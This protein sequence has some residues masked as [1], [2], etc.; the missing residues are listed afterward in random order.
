[1][2]RAATDSSLRSAGHAVA[3]ALAIALTLVPVSAVHAAQDASGDDS[4]PPV[5]RQSAEAPS[6]E[7]LRAAG[8]EPAPV[9]SEPLGVRLH[10][11][12]KSRVEHNE[13]RGK[14]SLLLADGAN[15]PPTW[16]LRVLR[17]VTVETN[18][19][20]GQRMADQIEKL[21]S[22]GGDAFTVSILSN[23]PMR[24][25]DREAQLA[26]IKQSFKEGQS[27]VSGTLLVPA[28]GRTM[29]AFSVY[30]TPNDLDQVRSLMNK[31]F[32]T[33]TLRDTSQV[34]AELSARLKNGRDLLA[35]LTPQRL[36][37]LAGETM[38]TRIYRP[39]GS[40][41][42][43]RG[44]QAGEQ[45]V[46]YSQVQIIK[47]PRGAVDFNKR[48]SNYNAAE[49]EQGLLVRIRG[50]VIGS[51]RRG[52]FYDSVAAYWVAWDQSEELWSVVGTHR[53]G[54]A[55]RSE[56]ETGVRMAPSVSRPEPILQVHRAEA[57]GPYEWM[58]P[59]V[60]LSQS[61]AWMLGKVLPRDIDEPREYAWYHYNGRE[62]EPKLT[63]RVDRWEK[64]DDGSGHWI[65][66][67]RLKPDAE[68]IIT[69]YDDEGNFIRQTRPDGV[70]MEPTT[71]KELRRLW[72][73]KGLP[74]N[75]GS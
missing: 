6:P 19:S 40:G 13:V 73:S 38:W 17:V 37:S 15:T 55:S 72:E 41:D 11:P 27:A 75:T 14:P 52:I 54:Q 24:I 68:A 36:Q 16:T 8:L 12:L 9:T 51:R 30:T 63:R 57:S 22:A 2:S 39:D 62:A 23:E 67:T 42:P 61:I 7:A 25:A 69:R 48:P 70:V 50:R 65:L 43:R 31:M 47:G 45:E 34:V 46:G 3:V 5:A 4:A 21:K 66:R 33:I 26:Y 32:Q 29:L 60:Y 53:Q 74:L 49:Q 64:A 28:G 58:V 18:P 56:A 71:L 59:N 20:A 44:V 35:S 10:P 1:M